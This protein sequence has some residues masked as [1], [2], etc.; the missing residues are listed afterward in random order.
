WW[1]VI[2][3]MGVQF[4]ARV[5]AGLCGCGRFQPCDGWNHC[6]HEPKKKC[7]ALPQPPRTT[8]EFLVK[9]HPAIKRQP[10]AVRDIHAN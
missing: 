5:G 10:N 6:T 7:Q 8:V 2:I 9:Q 4:R 1:C 3:I